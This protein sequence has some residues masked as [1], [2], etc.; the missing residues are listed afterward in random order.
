MAIL[1]QDQRQQT[2]LLVII[3]ALAG[4]ALYYNFI[5]SPG[6]QELVEL[7]DRVEDIETQNQLAEARA[8]VDRQLATPGASQ[9]SL[10]EAFGNLGRLYHAYDLI[11]LARICY[12][13]AGQLNAIE[14]N[15]IACGTPTSRAATSPSSP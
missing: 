1:P 3:L 6:G 8:I 13:N 4:G 5:H 10:S 2:M 15:P 7:T 12:R 11:E 9:A 14:A